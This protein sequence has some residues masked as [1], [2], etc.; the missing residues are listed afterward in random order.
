MG[1]ADLR[2]PYNFNKAAETS[3]RRHGKPS[4]IIGVFK[5]LLEPLRLAKP[6]LTSSL[7]LKPQ[8]IASFT[9]YQRLFPLI[10]E[11]VRPAEIRAFP[12]KTNFPEFTPSCAFS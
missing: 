2:K 6:M 10:K 7:L 12:G 4:A 3:H 1:S 5:D 11:K 9:P 8:R